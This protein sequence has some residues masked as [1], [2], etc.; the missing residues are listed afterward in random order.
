MPWDV[1]AGHQRM[2][3]RAVSNETAS[4]GTHSGGAGTWGAPAFVAQP[5]WRDGQGD[6]MVGLYA[7]DSDGDGGSG[8]EGVADSGSGSGR[9]AAC[10]FVGARVQVGVVG[11][12]HALDQTI[13]N[14]LALST[15]GRPRSPRC[16]PFSNPVFPAPSLLTLRTP[17]VFVFAER[18][19][20]S[21]GL[22]VLLSLS[23]PLAP[24][25]LQ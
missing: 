7:G 22:V 20:R 10:S 14:Q 1:G 16:Y 23:A 21:V 5:D 15:D 3:V 6:Q 24:E 12:F 17:V 8:A 13:D 25:P 9:F 18:Q 11:M 19:P 4:S 2:I